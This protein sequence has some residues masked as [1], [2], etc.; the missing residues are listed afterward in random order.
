MDVYYWPVPGANDDCVSTIGPKFNDPGTELLVTDDRGFPYW[1]AQTNPWGQNGSQDVDSIT[2]PP[3]QALTGA[4]NPLSVRTNIFKAR[5]YR[6]S[7]IIVAGN[8]SSTE[9]IATIGDLRW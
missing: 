4:I 3:Q 2:L 9:A 7:N 8:V 1:K 6:Q 5:E